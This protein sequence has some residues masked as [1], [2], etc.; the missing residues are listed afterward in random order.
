MANLIE[1]A[2]QL[3]VVRQIRGVFCLVQKPRLD[4]LGMLEQRISGL[5]NG[6]GPVLSRPIDP[7][8]AFAFLFPN[9]FDLRKPGHL[10]N[11]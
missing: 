11:P 9:G 3:Y 1:R 8:F 7:I 5:P 4:H 2:F 10:R 6:S